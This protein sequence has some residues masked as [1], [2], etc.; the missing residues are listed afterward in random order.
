MKKA[1]LLLAF[2]AVALL[3]MS[4]Q[5]SVDTLL[6][7][8]LERQM[9]S[10]ERVE[11]V[12]AEIAKYE[13]RLLRE[14][15]RFHLNEGVSLLWGMIQAGTNH[16]LIEHDG[17]FP[18]RDFEAQD[19][20]VAGVPLVTTWTLKALGV[21][22]RSKTRRMLTANVMALALTSGVVQGL[23]HSI[24]EQRP[25]GKDTQSF[26]SGHSA[27]AF[28][29]AAILEREYGHISPWITVGGYT[30][31][32]LTEWLRL[33]HHAHYINDIFTGAGIGVVTTNLAYFITDR[34]FGKDAINQPRLYKGDV[35]R[36]GR[37]LEQPVSLSLT[38]GSEI[39]SKRIGPAAFQALPSS[40]LAPED[41]TLRTSSTWTSGFDYSYFLNAHWAVDA[42]ARV[43]T[44]QLKADVY[45]A[46]LGN[47]DVQAALLHQY[48]FNLGMRY[49]LPLGLNTRFSLHAYGGSSYTQQ[50][51]IRLLDQ[52]PLIRIPH[53]WHPELGAGLGIEVLDTKNYVTGFTIDYLHQFS[54]I[55][56]NRCLVSTYWK[57]LL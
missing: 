11:K 16:S 42:S 29:S 9:D 35:V 31:A 40:P 21:E 10:L 38:A 54:D 49:S 18:Y 56:P 46:S 53:R 15:M 41:I 19:Y 27:I 22:S 3:R 52:T 28:M 12:K 5:E 23:K 24:H 51:D 37:F 44:T 20:A 48:H 17:R 30:T 47:S 39:T 57:I 50:T 26:P 1:S 34:I 6:L 25:N 4:A 43:A 55:F 32:T 14:E 33:R 45:H 2:F 13:N 36:L 7:K 8:A